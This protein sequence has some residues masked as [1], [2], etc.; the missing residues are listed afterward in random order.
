MDRL[1]RIEFREALE[2]LVDAL[3][4]EYKLAIN[5][6]RYT[7]DAYYHPPGYLVAFPIGYI[8]IEMLANDRHALSLFVERCKNE[9][10]NRTK[11]IKDGSE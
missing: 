7:I 10:A 8:T 2:K 4:S 6:R 5:K 1:T 9:V 11:V 3:P